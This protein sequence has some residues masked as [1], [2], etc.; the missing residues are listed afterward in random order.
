MRRAPSVKETI[1]KSSDSSVHPIFRPVSIRSRSPLLETD[2]NLHKSNSTY[3]SDLDIS[4]T[5]LVTN[6]LSAGF[7]SGNAKLERQGHKGKSN[8]ILGSVHTSYHKEIK[9]YELYE[10]RSRVIGWDQKWLVI[11]STFV[12]PK[13]GVKEE[14]VLASALSKYVVKKSRYT[15]PPERC[16]AAAGWFDGIDRPEK[17]EEGKSKESEKA[18][19]KP[20]GIL[21]LPATKLNDEPSPTES[22]VLVNRPHEEELQAVD[23]A[24][25]EAKAEE[26]SA[27]MDEKWGEGL[28]GS[29]VPEQA[30]ENAVR[31]V[32]IAEPPA[33]RSSRRTSGQ[34]WTWDAIEKERLRGLEIVR[35]WMALDGALLQESSRVQL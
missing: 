32:D 28:R 5:A 19:K 17:E 13:Q 10:V 23:I 16:L 8:V 24:K 11:L 3:F 4:R 30:T 9:P 29:T 31:V 33:Q 21:K 22:T 6:L 14:V 15:V 7:R 12:R 35:A 20:K 18:E 27:K 25:L 26:M 34:Q 2:Y 1:S